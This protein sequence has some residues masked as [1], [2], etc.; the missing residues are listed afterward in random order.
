MNLT[1][2]GIIRSPHQRAASTAGC[3]TESPGAARPGKQAVQDHRAWARKSLRR[4]RVR[5]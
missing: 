5:S 2:I 3:R 4:S 1:P